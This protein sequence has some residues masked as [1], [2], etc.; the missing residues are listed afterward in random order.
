MC[1]HL[2][3]RHVC[4]SLYTCA[5]VIC[6]KLL[7]AYLLTYLKHCECLPMPTTCELKHR[8]KG[9]YYTEEKV[10]TAWQSWHYC[11][12]CKATEQDSDEVIPGK[13]IWKQKHRWRFSGTAGRRW[14]QQHKTELDGDMSSVVYA[15]L[16]VSVTRYK[17]ILVT[18]KQQQTSSSWTFCWSTCLLS[19]AT[20]LWWCCVPPAARSIEPSSVC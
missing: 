9:H 17:S 10:M 11:G 3:Y 2:Y 18:C 12:H 14:K 8:N 4:I 6:I 16:A 15:P 13:R 20:S 5:N 19:D 7:L 1:F